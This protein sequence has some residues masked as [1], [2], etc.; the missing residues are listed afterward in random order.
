MSDEQNINIEKS[1]HVL[2]K[3]GVSDG[4]LLRQALAVNMALGDD[5][6][7]EWLG[8]LTEEQYARLMAEA[9]EMA[10]KIV[11]IMRPFF[12]AISS[13]IQHSAELFTKWYEENDI[14]ELLE[15]EEDG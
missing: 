12:D 3:L 11:E 5:G 6:T 10:D 1:E 4:A 7:R 9:S 2:N 14:A 8:T 15:D 13:A